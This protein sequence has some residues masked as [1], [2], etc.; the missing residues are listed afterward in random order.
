MQCVILLL[1]AIQHHTCSILSYPPTF[2]HVHHSH[3][4]HG[5]HIHIN[6]YMGVCLCAAICSYILNPMAR[7]NEIKVKRII[8]TKIQC[9]SIQIEI[10]E[11]FERI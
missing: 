4:N 10:N 3:A 7:N 8:Y 1:T 9:G 11:K 2:Y 6:I 5:E